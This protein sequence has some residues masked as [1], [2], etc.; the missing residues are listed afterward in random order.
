MTGDYTELH[1]HYPALEQ[2]RYPQFEVD[3]GAEMYWSNW[4]AV[5]TTW[6]FIQT[7]DLSIETFDV[8]YE[9]AGADEVVTLNYNSADL[10]DYASLELDRNSASQDS[11]I[12]LTITDNQLNI[13]PTGKDVVIFYVGLSGSEACYIPKSN[14]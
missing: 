14:C 11:D 9:Q 2:Y 10:D 12:H 1:Q 6:P 4:C 7:Y 5:Q 3:N 8:V 13:D